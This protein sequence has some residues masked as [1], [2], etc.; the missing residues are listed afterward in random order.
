MNQTSNFDYEILIQNKLGNPLVSVIVPVYNQGKTGF[1]IPCLNSLISQTF[2]NI[3][4]ICIDDASEDNSLDILLNY[5]RNYDCFTIIEMKENSRQG[6]A[7]NRGIE[8]AKGKYISFVD[9]DDLVSNNFY[10]ELYYTAEKNHC[11]AIEASFQYIDENGTPFGSISKPHK[12]KMHNL[13]HQSRERLIL[14]HGMIWSYLYSA[15]LFKENNIRFPEKIRYE[16][17][18]TLIRI[19]FKIAQVAPCQ[20]AIYK[21]RKNKF[22]T[23][24]ITSSSSVAIKERLAAA[25]MIL[26]D[27]ETDGIYHIYK[28]VLDYYFIKVY[29]INTLYIIS[30][31][32]NSHILNKKQLKQMSSYC[33]K[34][35]PNSINNPFIK[36]LPFYQRLSTIVAILSPRLYLI[37]RK[38]LIRM[39]KK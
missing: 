1:L 26:D 32:N 6:T 31:S 28:D 11:D 16:D 23:M 30:E 9:S 20:T 27:A 36:R 34:R 24:A 2:Q 14:S 37:L 10:E 29:L 13:D 33:K 17:T 39:S 19:I 5:A 4:I 21:Y 18:P 12:N 35:I 15:N 25:K 22:S 7:R 38:A 3:E 8:L